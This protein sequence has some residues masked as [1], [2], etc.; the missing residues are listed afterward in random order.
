M[1]N[2][3]FNRGREILMLDSKKDLGI[4]PSGIKSINRMA[5]DH[6]RLRP[7][8]KILKKRM[9]SGLRSRKA[10][11]TQTLFHVKFDCYKNKQSEKT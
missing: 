5:R 4:R 11:K 1:K 10:F 7:K 8:Q 9:K 2:N 3:S 6:S